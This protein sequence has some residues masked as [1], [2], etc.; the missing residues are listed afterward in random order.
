[1]TVE[2]LFQKCFSMWVGQF[3]STERLLNRSRFKGAMQATRLLSPLPGQEV[4]LLG[5]NWQNSLRLPLSDLGSRVQP[6]E[7]TMDG[8]KPL[9]VD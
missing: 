4:S 1:M 7:Y 8:E 6:Q 3:P 2:T 5:P 9:N